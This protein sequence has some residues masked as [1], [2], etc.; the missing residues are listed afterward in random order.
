M[1]DDSE[2][3]RLEKEFCPPIDPALFYSIWHDV[4]DQE[5]A[6]AQA[7]AMLDMLKADALQEQDSLFDPSG[8]SGDV[9]PADLESNAESWVSQTPL[10]GGSG[11]ST[12][13]SN[14]SLGASG[15]PSGSG[16]SE[17]SE[18]YFR[19]TESFDTQ[20]KE[21]VL[22]GIFPKLRKG[23]IVF[24]LRKCDGDF[25]KA[26]DELLNLVYF[27]G[28]DGI[29]AE[30]VARGIDAF[31][32]DHH[33]PHKGKKGKRKG[34]RKAKWTSYDSALAEDVDGT[35]AKS[36]TNKW[37]EGNKDVDFIASKTNLEKKAIASIY[38]ANGASRS[39]AILAIV[40]KDITAN[41]KTEPDA[42]ILNDALDLNAD[43]PALDL[44]HTLALIRLTTPST[45]SAH[46][47]AKALATR[48]GSASPISP[49]RIIPHYAP[50]QLPNPAPES[51]TRL[52]SLAPS[53]ISP[54]SAS[55]AEARSAAFTQASAAHRKGK[56]T[57]L[58][59]AAAGY[60]AQIGRDLTSH[61]HAMSELD[62]DAHVAA[63][64]SSTVL[65]LHGVSVHNATRIAKLRTR[66][67]WDGLGEKRIPGGGR[68]TGAGGYRIVTGLGRHSEG[69]RGV[70]G[71]A[72]G[73][74]LIKEGW[75]VEFATG[76]LVV[77][78]LARRR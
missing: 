34:G 75:K 62:A 54:S 22:C 63:Q 38:H 68:N 21:A 65:D 59:K 39:A 71:P 43:F 49:T 51:P 46:E 52:P 19:D 32:E 74:V 61:L 37:Q 15:S 25:E 66:A 31:S 27:E 55:L 67:W 56:S 28:E 7:R 42:G 48:S 50:L 53:L 33:I 60:Y 40:A 10:T 29:P 35:A 11:L 26:T 2:I 18:G 23:L 1:V 72:V 12:D 44:D 4:H 16:S 8:S 17:S 9:M 30:G 73:K 69:G 3:E 41:R 45:A 36:G 14:L 57:P 77:S 24:R 20:T 58:M 64:S 13:V 78:G 6:V 76:E 5:D 47:L 70:L